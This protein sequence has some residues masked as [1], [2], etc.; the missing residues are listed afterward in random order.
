MLF[1]CRIDAAI[2]CEDRKFGETDSPRK[3]NRKRLIQD[4]DAMLVVIWEMQYV[5]T[6]KCY[7]KG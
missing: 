2:K 4:S 6:S 3:E 7:A 1:K 5:P